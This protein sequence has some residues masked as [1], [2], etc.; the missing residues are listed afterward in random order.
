MA[1]GSQPG[2]SEVHRSPKGPCLECGGLREPGQ[3][4]TYFAKL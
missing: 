1:R 4:V 2:A 3:G